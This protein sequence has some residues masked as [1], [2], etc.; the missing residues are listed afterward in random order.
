M[1]MTAAPAFLRL[2]LLTLAMAL[3]ELGMETGLSGAP[4]LIRKGIKRRCM[5]QMKRLAV[6]IRR[7]IFLMALGLEAKPVVP[8]QGHN[9][10]TPAGRS[11]AACSGSI[12]GLSVVPACVRLRSNPSLPAFALAGRSGPSA[13]PM[14][15]AAPA[16]RR[17]QSLLHTLKH[18]EVYA[19]RL[20]KKLCAWKAQ[21][22]PAP[23]LGEI[24]NLHRIPAPLALVIG[25][26]SVQIAEA[27]KA[28]DTG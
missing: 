28:W 16:L 7:L 10:V 23:I 18:H 8:R 14:V 1:R 12:R 24:P 2:A 17:W 15:P 13:G 20:A 25:G 11:G 4:T 9:Q 27:L 6:L 3:A 19:Q 5:G 21:H 26:M 22:A